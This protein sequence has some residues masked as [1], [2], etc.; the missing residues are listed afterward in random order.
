MRR[1]RRKRTTRRRGVQSI[2][3]VLSTILTDLEQLEEQEPV[4]KTRAETP[5]LALP[6]GAA[7]AQG[8]FSFY[9]T[10]DV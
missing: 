1:Q 9:Q 2:G 7:N 3:E 8:T 10:A 6:V 4:K 5:A